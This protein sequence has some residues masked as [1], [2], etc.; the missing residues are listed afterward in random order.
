MPSNLSYIKSLHEFDIS[1]NQQIDNSNHLNIE[2]NRKTEKIVRINLDLN[3]VKLFEKYVNNHIIKQV[4]NYEFFKAYFINIKS[5]L[6]FVDCK[7][8][9]EYLSRK[10]ILNL[11]NLHQIEN[12]LANCRSLIF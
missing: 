5:N 8:Q 10:I 6:E 7:L 12:F 9:I 1:F 11:F 4:G 3:S 2:L